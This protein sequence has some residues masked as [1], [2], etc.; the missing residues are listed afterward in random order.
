MMEVYQ[1]WCEEKKAG[2]CDLDTWTMNVRGWSD[3]GS[4]SVG[5]VNERKRKMTEKTEGTAITC[6]VPEKLAG[7][8]SVTGR[9]VV[10]DSD[11][12][13]DSDSDR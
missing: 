1:W 9:Y 6:L 10:I 13:S 2:L 7:K 12:D 3:D 11:S 5:D 4:E 8:M